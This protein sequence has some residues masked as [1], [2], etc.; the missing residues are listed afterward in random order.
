MPKRACSALCAA[1]V[2]ECIAD[3]WEGNAA[4]WARLADVSPSS[5]GYYSRPGKDGRF[6][7]V[8]ALEKLIEPLPEEWQ[9]RLVAGYA[10]DL[11]PEKHRGKFK[12]VGLKEKR[13][14]RLRLPPEAERVLDEMRRRAF[15]DEGVMRWLVS[16]GKAMFGL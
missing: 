1:A 8:E 9:V 13:E 15:R 5:V 12:I 11:V 16:T 14:P 6:P 7:S 3:Y 10:M 2:R 4:E